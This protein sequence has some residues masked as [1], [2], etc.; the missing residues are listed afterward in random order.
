M[1]SP[2]LFH[3][4]EQLTELLHIRLTS[5]SATKLGILNFSGTCESRTRP[6]MANLTEGKPYVRVTRK[7][8]Y[9]SKPT[10]QKRIRCLAC[11]IDAVTSEKSCAFAVFFHGRRF[12]CSANR[13][14]R[15]QNFQQTRE[16][17]AFRLSS[18]PLLHFDLSAFL[19]YIIRRNTAKSFIKSNLIDF[20]KQLTHIFIKLLPKM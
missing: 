11:V 14:N 10:V 8:F 15:Q 18:L 17:R 2:S 20:C 7:F 1:S 9:S 4:H 5:V 6:A 16:G 3:F 19:H 13:H 12:F